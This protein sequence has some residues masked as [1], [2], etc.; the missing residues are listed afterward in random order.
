MVSQINFRNKIVMT[1]ENIKL[2]EFVRRH[3]YKLYDNN[4]KTIILNDF[5]SRMATAA[6][7]KSC[8]QNVYLASVSIIFFLS[9]VSA[10]GKSLV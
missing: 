10:Q 8:L 6:M 4:K 1:T 5:H 2:I 7:K 9:T 3:S